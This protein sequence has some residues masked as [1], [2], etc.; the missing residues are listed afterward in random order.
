MDNVIQLFAQSKPEPVKDVTNESYFFTFAGTTFHF[1]GGAFTRDLLER[2]ANNRDAVKKLIDSDAAMKLTALAA[3]AE[4]DDET[5]SLL[6]TVVSSERDV[7]IEL[8]DALNTPNDLDDYLSDDDSIVFMRLVLAATIHAS[9][10]P[11]D[12][13]RMQRANW[14]LIEND[15]TQF[16]ASLDTYFTSTDKKIAIIQLPERSNI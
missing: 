13:L 4:L 11:F 10:V 16:M 1:G 7:T 5:R 3:Y 2:L 6:E 8:V 12:L 15:P 9:Y 14:C